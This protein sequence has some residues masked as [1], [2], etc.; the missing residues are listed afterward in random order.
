MID[1]AL[2]IVRVEVFSSCGEIWTLDE[3]L[4]RAA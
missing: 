2:L 4:D 1:V 3:L